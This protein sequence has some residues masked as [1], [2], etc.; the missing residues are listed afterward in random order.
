MR[1][2][3]ELTSPEAIEL[4][5]PVEEAHVQDAGAVA[6]AV[7]EAEVHQGIQSEGVCVVVKGVDEDSEKDGPYQV[8]IT[9]VQPEFPAWSAEAALVDG[10][11]QFGALPEGT[12]QV[13][14]VYAS[15]ESLAGRTLAWPT[16]DLEN[17]RSLEMDLDKIRA[18]NSENA[19]IA[20]LRAIHAAQRQMQ[21]C[22]AIDTDG[23]GSG[24]YAYFGELAGSSPLRAFGPNGGTVGGPTEVLNPPFLTRAF[25]NIQAGLR[26]GCVLRQGYYFRVQLPALA[27]SESEPVAG[28][29][30]SP[31]GGASDPVDPSLGEKY[32]G[33]Y[34]WPAEAG[35]VARST[36]FINQEGDLVRRDHSQPNPYVGLNA[37]PSFDA[38][39][40]SKTPR[41]MCAAI[42]FAAR[43]LAANDGGIWVQVGN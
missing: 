16:S 15:M 26:Y 18:E 39:L 12:L 24:Q 14:L 31:L 20:T 38:A 3:L 30:E 13:E 40:S 34:A 21:A 7:E 36:F 6:Q 29:F 5:S 22:C 10:T 19:A 1:P 23:D 28:V 25:G 11:A 43:G 27:Y 42:A 37:G 8:R 32:W 4:R 17:T 2:A 41:D 33:V 35:P 9:R